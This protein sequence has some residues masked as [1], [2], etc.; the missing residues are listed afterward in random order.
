M[1]S[2]RSSSTLPQRSSDVWH[3]ETELAFDTDPGGRGES[4]AVLVA[5]TPEHEY[6][7]RVTWRRRPR[8]MK[9]L[10]ERGKLSAAGT[11]VKAG[12]ELSRRR[13]DT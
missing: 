3:P 7:V 11:R 1:R 5:D 6:G 2:R 13:A 10:L 8:L 9:Y 12:L 4:A